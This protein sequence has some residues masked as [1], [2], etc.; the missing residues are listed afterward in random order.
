MFEAVD[1]KHTA[2][3]FSIVGILETAG[4][5]V[6]TAVLSGIWIGAVKLG[7]PALGFPFFASTVS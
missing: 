6:G 7:G 4:E 2:R 1:D 3:V 5:L